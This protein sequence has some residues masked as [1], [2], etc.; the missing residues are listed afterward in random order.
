MLLEER[1]RKRTSM[2]LHEE[3]ASFYV[4]AS[5]CIL[6]CDIGKLSALSTSR[7]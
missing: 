5:P 7:R 1:A 6:F 3:G 2:C 4:S